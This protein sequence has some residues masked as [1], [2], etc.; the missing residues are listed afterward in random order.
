MSGTGA[1][2]RE[3]LLDGRDRRHA[4]AEFLQR[5][6]QDVARIVLVFDDEHADSLEIGRALLHQLRRGVTETMP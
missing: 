4:R 6:A 1:H 3:R 5:A 2:V